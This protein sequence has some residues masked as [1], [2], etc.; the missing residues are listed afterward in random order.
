M[1]VQSENLKLK[2]EIDKLQGDIANYK[3]QVNLLLIQLSQNNLNNCSHTQISIQNKVV[4]ASPDNGKS[5]TPLSENSSPTQEKNQDHVETIEFA[6]STNS[7]Q[8]KSQFHGFNGKDQADQRLSVEMNERG[9]EE[10]IINTIEQ[11]KN[12]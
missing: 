6:P 4:Y 8:K 12:H 1:N 9:T 7:A 11:F 10:P 2:L 3:T 5:N